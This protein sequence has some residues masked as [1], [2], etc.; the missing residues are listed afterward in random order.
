[1]DA[2]KR[3]QVLRL[4][5]ED[6]IPLTVLADESGVPLRSLERWHARFRASGTAGLGRAVRADKGARH[7]DPGLVALTEGIALH[8]PRPAITTIHRLV[9]AAAA[10]RGLPAPSYGV[11]REI[12][13]SID[14]AM[15]TLA[16]EGTASYRDKHELALRR[17]AA[18]PNEMWQAD[19]S[20]LDL[21]VLDASGRPARPWLTVIEDDHSLS[22]P[23]F[24]GGFQWRVLLSGKE[25]RNHVT[26]G[27]D[28][29][30]GGDAAP[31]RQAG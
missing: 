27:G 3:W 24:R 9:T 18:A 21:L 28:R 19:H 31:P 20:E 10:E 7:A 8:R 2:A 12:V 13:R 11:V 25:S 23:E 4:H 22:C 16:L 14:P 30:A 29:F 5:V 15:V 26:S 17:R 6:D 1:M